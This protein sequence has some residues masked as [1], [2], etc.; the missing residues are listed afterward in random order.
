MTSL[1][2]SAPLDYIIESVL[3]PNRKIKEGYH[4]IVVFTDDGRVFTG[5]VVRE[6]AQEVVLRDATD[7]EI[8]I[9]VKE[10]EHRGS[11]GSLMP[12]GL[13]DN[14]SE[15]DQLDL[16]RFLG[17]LGRPGRFDATKSRAA[18]AWRIL[19]VSHEDQALAVKARHGDPALPW[20]TITTTVAGW[21]PRAEVQKLAGSTGTTLLAATRF[22]VAKPASIRF[23]TNLTGEVPAWLD[24]QEA[25]LNST[26]IPVLAGKHTLVVQVTPGELP[27]A[28][29]LESKDVV[30]LARD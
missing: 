6:T 22:E 11:A 17:E 21:L 25:H 18:R 4:A 27:E 10:I 2:A 16:Y 20:T 7:K 28:F 29:T 15:Q 1:G 12:A 8:T 13:V 9:P 26:S 3:L 19:A 30:F 23:Q 5:I 14:L 24:G